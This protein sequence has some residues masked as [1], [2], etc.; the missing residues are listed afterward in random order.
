MQDIKTTRRVLKRNRIRAKI[1]GTPKR[2]R[3]SV[4]VS[5]QAVSAQLIDD[6]AGKTLVSATSLKQKDLRGKSL[7]EQ[8]AWVGEQI[9]AKAKKDKITEAVFDRGRHIYHG[10]VKAL[11]EA[12]RKAGLKI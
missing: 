7:T 9:A 2:P 4:R 8:S 10:R 1:S 11:A 12:A 6:V 5:L 3:L